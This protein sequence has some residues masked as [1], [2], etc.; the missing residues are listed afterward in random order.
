MAVVAERQDLISRV[1]LTSE[2]NPTGVYWVRL[3]IDGK[4]KQYPVDNFFPL[5]PRDD[6]K[7]GERGKGK[8]TLTFMFT[9]IY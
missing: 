1:I 7:S 3:F 9:R 5:R 2:P 4:W 6:K 8:V